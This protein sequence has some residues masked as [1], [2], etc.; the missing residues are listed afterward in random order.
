MCWFSSASSLKSN[1]SKTFDLQRQTGKQM[2]RL[3]IE[4]GLI[5]EELLVNGTARQLRASLVNLK[6]FPVVT[7]PD[8]A[9]YLRQLGVVIRFD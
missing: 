8:L 7:K 3:L 2:G 1:C 5:A 9:T 4:T 6:T